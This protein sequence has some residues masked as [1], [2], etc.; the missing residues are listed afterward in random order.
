MRREKGSPESAIWLL[1][2]S[3]PRILLD[4]HYE[5][6]EPLDWRFPTRHNIWTPIE[7]I[8]NRE[9]FRSLR[10][11]IDDSKFYVRNAVK[12]TGDWKG[13]DIIA[14]EVSILQKLMEPKRPLIIL[15][16]GRR[17]FEFA[18]QCL[19]ETPVPRISDW[20]IPEL[21][22]EFE[23]RMS[24]LREGEGILLPL[25][26]AVVARQFATCHD[27]FGGERNPKNYYE[28]VGRELATFLHGQFGNERLRNLLMDEPLA[29]ELD[30]ASSAS[31]E[32]T[33]IPGF[34]CYRENGASV[35]NFA[36]GQGGLVSEP[37]IPFRLGNAE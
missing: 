14:A 5:D 10:K 1:A 25:L 30:A 20:G 28:H 4:G 2:D 22:R 31:G 19:G 33:R 18:R 8:I 3:P 9:L 23:S 34:A 37:S 35:V 15:T 11:R 29:C 6:Y 36:I 26:H 12:M 13:K 7:T 24:R 21:S 32:E 27:A 16:F 17:S